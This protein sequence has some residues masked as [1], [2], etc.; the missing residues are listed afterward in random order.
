MNF[1][2]SLGNFGLERQHPEFAHPANKGQQRQAIKPDLRKGEELT[3]TKKERNEKAAIKD[4]HF[5]IMPQYE[6]FHMN[7]KDRV[8]VE[9]K[10]KAFLSP[11]FLVDPMFTKDKKDEEIVVFRDN[12]FAGWK[13][14][15]S[16]SK[17]PII[18]KEV[19]NFFMVGEDCTQGKIS[20]KKITFT[21]PSY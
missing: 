7:N 18:R 19:Q 12:D 20:G 13:Q 5:G 4:P 2:T 6:L 9:A 11:V 8:P 3:M 14:P 21:E 15:I 16:Q 17:F 1:G 10:P